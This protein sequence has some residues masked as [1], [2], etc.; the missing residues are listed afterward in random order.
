MWKTA[1]Q[2]VRRGDGDIEGLV[3]AF[4][5]AKAQSC[6]FSFQQM[7]EQVFLWP[8]KQNIFADIGILGRFDK[9]YYQDLTSFGI[10]PLSSKNERWIKACD[11]LLMEYPNACV[12]PHGV[13][14]SSGE[15]EGLYDAYYLKNSEGRI[16]AVALDFLLY[17]EN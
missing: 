14:S 15:G 11:D 4:L 16:I 2:I 3:P 13:I 5:L 9:K 17:G 10:P 8:K 6:P 1:V 7:P 12:L